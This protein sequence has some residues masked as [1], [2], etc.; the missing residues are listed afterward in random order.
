MATTRNFQLLSTSFLDG[1]D[2]PIKF[3]SHGSNVS[4]ALA[5][6][7]APPDAKSFAL[8]MEDPDAP[9]G[10]FMHWL[11]YNLPASAPG[12]PEDFPKTSQLRDG[13]LQGKNGFGTIGYSGPR[14]PPN[15]QH[16]YVFKLYALNLKLK[17]KPGADKIE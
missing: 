4:P 6:S 10:S 16:K 14:P 11:V 5:W 2:I 1:G 13:T 15:I 17:C 9:G 3:T 7:Q 8:T 12:L